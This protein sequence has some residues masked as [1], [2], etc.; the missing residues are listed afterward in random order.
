MGIHHVE[1]N[2]LARTGPLSRQAALAAA[3][4][5]V[6]AYPHASV[7]VVKYPRAS[8]VRTVVA[9][10]QR[11]ATDPV[12]AATPTAPV[13][14]TPVDATPV[15]ATPVDAT[16]VDA[17]P[18]DAAYREAWLAADTATADLVPL[19]GQLADVVAASVRALREQGRAVAVAAGLPI[20]YET[21]R[22]ILW[23]LEDHAATRVADAVADACSG[24]D[25]DA[26]PVVV[27]PAGDSAHFACLQRC[28]VA[29]VRPAVP[30][31]AVPTGSWFA[32]CGAR[33]SLVF[34]NVA[35]ALEYATG[36]AAPVR[37]RSRRRAVLPGESAPP[38]AP[39][40]GDAAPT[41]PTVR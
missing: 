20:A 23:S 25:A 2:G 24:Y 32:T 21:A 29:A 9:Y 6:A 26:V 40:H 34:P 3:A 4:D 10:V 5:A 41:L 28:G 16:P 22:T 33:P 27:V 38:I 14:A 35:D 31:D 36:H 11:G 1:I 17:T 13:D 18:V 8:G 12:L 39:S 37:T 30:A 15:D 19:S 7:T